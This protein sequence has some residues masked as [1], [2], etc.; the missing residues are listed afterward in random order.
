MY[1]RFFDDARFKYR[2]HYFG[3]N[4]LKW[5]KFNLLG[6]VTNVNRIFLNFI[7]CSGTNLEIKPSSEK[8]P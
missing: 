6:F 8:A 4:D 1:Q 3:K 7:H 2:H 5:M